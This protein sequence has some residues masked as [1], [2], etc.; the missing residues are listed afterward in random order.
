MALIQ[1]YPP[2]HRT[3]ATLVSIVREVKFSLELR[4]IEMQWDHKILKLKQTELALGHHNDTDLLSEILQVIRRI[5]EHYGSNN[6]TLVP[7][8]TFKAR[9]ER[10]LRGYEEEM[11][12]TVWQKLQEFRSESAYMYTPCNSKRANCRLVRDITASIEE[13]RYLLSD[14]RAKLAARSRAESPFP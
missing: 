4:R 13:T 2:E 12:R 5:R 9:K 14:L 6:A 3:L 10:E 7:L 1:Y 11:F 8:Q